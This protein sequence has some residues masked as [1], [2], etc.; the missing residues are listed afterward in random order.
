MSDLQMM[1]ARVKELYGDDIIYFVSLIAAM[2]LFLVSPVVGFIGLYAWLMLTAWLIWKKELAPFTWFE[3]DIAK[4]ALVF[5]G[6]L[7]VFGISAYTVAWVVFAPFFEFHRARQSGR[8]LNLKRWAIGGTIYYGFW[9]IVTIV[10][11]LLVF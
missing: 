11:Y 7:T 1:F 6:P 9:I 2:L 8:K 3:S 4:W 5:F 10:V